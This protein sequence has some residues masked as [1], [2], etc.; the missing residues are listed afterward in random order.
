MGKCRLYRTAFGGGD[1]LRDYSDNEDPVLDTALNFSVDNFIIDPMGYLTQL[2]MDE[3]Y[4]LVG[5][6][7]PA[8]G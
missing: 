1:D 2:F 5:Y 4:E 7:S 6:G 3:K 8:L